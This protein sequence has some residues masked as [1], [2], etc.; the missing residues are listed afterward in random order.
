[1]AWEDVKTVTYARGSQD[2][3][4]DS[5]YG[6]VGPVKVTVKLQRNDS[7]YNVA[8]KSDR[9]TKLRMRFSYTVDFTGDKDHQCPAIYIWIGGSVQAFKKI[10]SYGGLADYSGTY[11]FI[12]KKDAY[13]QTFKM[14][15]YCIVDTGSDNKNGAPY[16]NQDFGTLY[17]ATFDHYYD[18]SLLDNSTPT[19][20]TSNYASHISM[21]NIKVVDNN[22]N[23]FTVTIGKVSSAYNNDI[24]SR[25]IEWW[26][27]DDA[28]NKKTIS[29]NTDSLDT[30]IPLGTLGNANARN[31]TVQDTVLADYEGQITKSRSTSILQ[32]IAP[33]TSG[34]A[35]TISVSQID[36]EGFFSVSWSNLKAT[37]VN[38]NS[39]IKGY[40]V[41]I[42]KLLNGNWNK[43]LE[44]Q[45]DGSSTVTELNSLSAESYGITSGQKLRIYVTVWTVTGTNSTTDYNGTSLSVATP[46]KEYTFPSVHDWE[47]N[48]VDIFN[49]TF[50]LEASVTEGYNNSLIDKYFSCRYADSSNSAWIDIEDYTWSTGPDGRLIYT[51]S[52]TLEL[53][54][55]KQTDTRSLEANITIVD[56]FGKDYTRNQIKNIKNY[57]RPSISGE[58]DVSCSFVDG[59]PLVTCSWDA[60]VQGNNTS[61][62]KGYKITISWDGGSKTL[63]TDSADTTFTFSPITDYGIALGKAFTVD[64]LPY[65][66]FGENNDGDYFFAVSGIEGKGIVAGGILRVRV[67]NE[68]REGQVYVYTKESANSNTLVWKPTTGIYVRSDGKWKQSI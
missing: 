59:S 56:A 25:K 49:N 3:V 38:S 40:K 42:D 22:N 32:Y 18:Y 55:E 9:L 7:V 20:T 60:A 66:K 61:P 34:K 44:Q 36:P 64:I 68:W 5:T 50:K 62:I 19:L 6:N 15:G 51:W 1:M 65:T 43:V 41:N 4:N 21:P 2:V 54:T 27:S 11:E 23:S 46:Y 63:Y 48:I 26:Y 29:T 33:T 67:G 16:Q 37:A 13:E 14:P 35:P 39:P 52:K 58:V 45:Y 24:T 8:S 28:S 57:I 30:T 31:V 53:D 12:L 47:L 17:N 10:G